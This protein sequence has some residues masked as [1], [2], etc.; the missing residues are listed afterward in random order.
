MKDVRDKFDLKIVSDRETSTYDMRFIAFEYS[1]HFE[2]FTL[3]Y[4]DKEGRRNIH[5]IEDIEDTLLLSC[6]LR[7]QYAAFMEVVKKMEKK[8]YD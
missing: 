2:K 5:D 3:T 1:L 6:G 4:D 8:I 7:K